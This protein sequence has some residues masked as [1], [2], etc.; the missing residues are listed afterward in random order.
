MSNVEHKVVDSQT[1]Y[2]GKV[3]TLRIDEIVLDNGDTKKREI[4]VHPP[5]IVIVPFFE[6]EGKFLMIEQFRDPIRRSLWEFPAGMVTGS[7]TPEETADREL[8]EETGYV[9]KKLDI[10]GQYYTS[11]GFTDELHHLC[12]A[13][14]LVQKYKQAQDTNEVTRTFM[15]PQKTLFQ[16]IKSGEIQDGKTILAYYWTQ[17]F[18]SRYAR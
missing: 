7:E 3:V 5:C 15:I 4:V 11:P 18:L 12:L 14:N 2:D 17:S 6:K 16:K 8:Q 1:I 13:R 9:A 10:I